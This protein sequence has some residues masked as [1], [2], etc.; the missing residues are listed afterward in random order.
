MDQWL[1]LTFILLAAA[2]LMAVL[3]AWMRLPT[4]LGYLAAGVLV[5]PTL[6]SIVQ[7][8]E[9]MRYLAELGVVLLMFMVGLEFSVSELWATRHDVL[10]A[11]GLQTLLT[12]LTVGG[13]VLSL[14]ASTQAAVLL[15]GAAAMSSTAI[16]AQQLADQGEL[17]TRYG[18]TAVAVL[19][20]QDVAAIPLLS[21]L[22]IWSRGEHTDALALIVEVTYTL[23][24][25]AVVGA[26][27]KPVVQRF[28]AWVARHGSAEVFLLAALVVV[29]GAALGARMVGLSAALGAFLA[30]VVLGESDFKHR[31][32]DDIR[33]FRDV[34]LGVFFI[35]VGLQLDVAQIVHSPGWV[36]LWLAA[37]VLL[38]MLLTWLA[39]R[40]AGLGSVDAARTAIILS[41]GGEFGLLLLSSSLAAGIV[42]APLG[43]PALVAFLLSMGLGPLLI[44]YHDAIVNRLRTRTHV[45]PPLDEERD[46]AARAASLREHVIICG[47]GKLGRLVAQAL[48]LANKPHIMV[49]SDF[50]AYAQARAAGY[51][52]LF[53]DASRIGTLRAAGVDRAAMAIIT[54]HRAQPAA[55]I[56]AAIRHECPRLDVVATILDDREAQTLLAIPGI[57][58]F[59]EQVAAGLALA[60]QALLAVGFSAEQADELI[61][62]LRLMLQQPFAQLKDTVE[63]GSGK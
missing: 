33:P 36:L 32:E 34:L 21:L 9:A 25:F 27:A 57:R 14:G 38:K 58:V 53:G 8:S 62:R 11:G 3:A 45:P 56:A 63:G 50:E 52:V 46:T 22:A 7:P 31:I 47:A 43:Q 60:E 23:G 42:A 26:L 40:A 17:T 5:G 15:G 20:F 28:L 54:F 1:T 30:G 44:R 19:V 35:T 16:A 37:V 6:L 41:H 12:G 51:N 49:E 48:M 18:R 29:V 59:S 24:L 4:L 13:I 2:A 61:H 10:V 39:T 55:R